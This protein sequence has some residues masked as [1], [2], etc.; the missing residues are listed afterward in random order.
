MKTFV[1]GIKNIVLLLVYFVIMTPIMIVSLVQ[2][3]GGAEE[4]IQY[5]IFKKLGLKGQSDLINSTHNNIK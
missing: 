4:T 5:K 3:V 1:K 2:I